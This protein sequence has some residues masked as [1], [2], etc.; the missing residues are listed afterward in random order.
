M[1]GASVHNCASF[2]TDTPFLLNEVDGAEGIASFILGKCGCIDGLENF[3]VI[4]LTELLQK[5]IHDCLSM[6]GNSCAHGHLCHDVTKNITAHVGGQLLKS[7]NGS[8]V[9]GCVSRNSGCR[10]GRPFDDQAS[11]HRSTHGCCKGYV[12]VQQRG[13]H[14][15]SKC[16]SRPVGQLS[17][18]VPVVLNRIIRI[19]IR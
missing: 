14:I 9:A 6:L 4:Q 17:G 13:N 19:A 7:F 16:D 15:F 10:P 3:L 2:E 12:H 18:I 1:L 11:V 8:R 5:C